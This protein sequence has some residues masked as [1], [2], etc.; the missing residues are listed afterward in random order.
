MSY[1]YYDPL[2]WL[3]HYR[4]AQAGE[5]MPQHD[6]SPWAHPAFRSCKQAALNLLQIFPD[7]Q[8]VVV[9]P[10]DCLAPLRLE[11][12]LAGRTL[13]V[14]AYDGKRLVEIPKTALRQTRGGRHT[15]YIDDL[16]KAG[17]AYAGAV[18]VIVVAALAFNA[19]MRRVYSFEYRRTADVIAAMRG[20]QT[21]TPPVIVLAS[22]AQEI[23]D[24][25]GYALG[26]HE[27]DVVVTAT[28][29]IILGAG[30]QIPFP[31]EVTR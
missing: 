6:D 11:T 3:M 7:A 26:A 23:R 20:G 28:R 25:P 4:L 14:P 21:A 10:D 24:W 8:H 30:R 18:D 2:H 31:K 1:T 15:L 27:A 12:L 16:L 13:I 17:P 19:T 9:M 22:D 5:T 29:S